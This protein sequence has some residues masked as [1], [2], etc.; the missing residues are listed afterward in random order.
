MSARVEIRY[1]DGKGVSLYSKWQSSHMLKQLKAALA[2]H[3]R[4]WRD[5]PYLSRV[6]YENMREL[7]D[8]VGLGICQTRV[9]DSVV[10]IIEATDS[11]IVA[12]VDIMAQTVEFGGYVFGDGGS[13]EVYSETLSFNEFIRDVRGVK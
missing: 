11:E 8:G 1:A 5:P 10:D 2:R 13:V 6:I 4:Y 9:E 12:I 3:P 7:P